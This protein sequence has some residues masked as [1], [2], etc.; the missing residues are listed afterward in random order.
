MVVTIKVADS[1]SLR[2]IA[3]EERSVLLNYQSD[4]GLVVPGRV[5]EAQFT[6]ASGS[7][8]FITY[9]IPFEEQ[10]DILLIRAD[11]VIVDRASLRAALTTGSFRNPSISEPDTVCFDFFGGHRWRARI[12]PRARFRVPIASDAI[13]VHRPF[14]WWRHLI[15]E[16]GNMKAA[17]VAT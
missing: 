2:P 12:L 11:A 8:L 7:L 15:V 5:L 13:G 3:G 1:Y 17:D 10:L 16:P 14:S 6:A 9:D 4:T